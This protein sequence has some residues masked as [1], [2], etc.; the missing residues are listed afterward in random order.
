MLGVFGGLVC[1][2]CTLTAFAV[3]YTMCASKLPENTMYAYKFGGLEI[4]VTVE[5]SYNLGIGEL[6][7]IIATV[8]QF[9]AFI[10]QIVVQT[11]EEHWGGEPDD[12]TPL[13]DKNDELVKAIAKAKKRAQ[14]TAEGAG[15]E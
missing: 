2:A 5:Y 4:P 12:N 10:N 7:L 13:L 6:S 1:F 14:E 3:Y 8:F 15:K 9:V 11:P